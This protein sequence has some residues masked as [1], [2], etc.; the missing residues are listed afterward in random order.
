[1]AQGVV[2]IAEYWNNSFRKISI[3]AVCEG[4]RLAA[5]LGETLTAVV[6]GAGVTDAASELAKYGADKIIVADDPALKSFRGEAYANVLCDILAE[7]PARMVI[8]GS[9]NTGIELSARAA[10]RMGVGLATACT[11]LKFD[12]GRLVATRPL[13]GGR[14]IAEVDI[15]GTPQM[16]SIR[17]NMMAIVESEAP[18][19]VAAFN[20]N[21][22]EVK[23]ELLEENI[24]VSTKVDLTEADYVVSGGRGMNGEDFSILE[25][26]ATLLGGAIGASR[27]AVDAGWRPHSDQVGQTGKVVSPKLYLACGISGAM[28]HTAGISTSDTIVA[29]NN[30]PDALIFRVA[31]YCII[32]DLFE[33]VPAITSEIK[34]LKG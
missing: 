24:E 26:L 30:D 23:V 27:N 9:T 33:V 28:Q 32:D 34:A 31:D 29:I 2:V 19:E 10:A 12:D 1:M 14:A 3:E 11:A 18:G 22:G 25:E 16:V 13:Y 17:P 5:E 20:V 8:T 4:K 15:A 7:Y 21:V 6:M